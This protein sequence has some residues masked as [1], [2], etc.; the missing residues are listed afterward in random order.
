MI[1]INS[2]N[3]YN[4]VQL[5]YG[6]K[7]YKLK[8]PANFD[9]IEP[10][11]IKEVGSAKEEISKALLSPINS[12]PLRSLLEGKNDIAISVCDITRAQ[13]RKV[14][15]ETI[16]EHIKDLIPISN[17]KILIATGTH[18]ANTKDELIEMLGKDI[19][20]TLNVINHVCDDKESLIEMPTSLDDVNVL[21]NK[22]WVNADFR[23]TTGFV[24]P[25]FFAGFSGGSKLVAPGLAGLKT[26]MKLHNY[27]RLNNPNSIWGEVEKNP[28]QQDVRK[29]AKETGVDFTLDVALN[30]DQKITNVF[31]GDLID[32]HNEACNFA[33]ETAM[34]QVSQPYDLV[35]TSNSGYPLDQNLYQ[36]VK[37]LSAAS[38]IV[39]DN[40]EILCLS[41]CSDGIPS[42]G[43][44]YSLLS[45]FSDP[46]QVEGMLSDPNF[47]CQDQWQVQ[48]LSQ[49]AK[50]SNINLYTEGL[51]DKEIENAFMFNAPDPQK[52]IDQ[53]LKENANI[54]G[55]V[56]PEG[57]ITIP[58][59]KNN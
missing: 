20:E 13:P 10:K 14:V 36:T 30:R 12:K 32:S 51:S 49:I 29:I 44:F 37:G 25:H 18:R 35:I 24:E 43:K 3:K 34:V 26:I 39:K 11:F 28:I 53:K 17:I 7:G 57:P 50:K 52:F 58:I 33:R 55:C 48:I 40:G 6:K 8:V 54:R 2:E 15:I 56:L 21:L 46:E 38:Q 4:E 59:L 1:L 9:V 19:V 23:I 42:H 31:S 22:H 41:E 47:H 16:V 27:K 5:A 45:E